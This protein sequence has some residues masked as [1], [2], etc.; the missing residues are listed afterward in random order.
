M[1]N[2]VINVRKE[3]GMTSFGVVSRMRRI[4][5]QKKIGHT[6]TLDPDAEGVLP[7]C[8]GKATRLVET[9][10]RGTKS[11]RAVLLLGMTTDT[12]DA[13]GT[14]LSTSDPAISEEALR[15]LILS[16]QGK[17]QQL[18]PMYSALKVDG[19]KLVDLA[20]RGIEVERKTREV[21][22]SEM[23]VHSVC[24]PRAEFSVTCTHGAYIRTLCHDIGQ[25]AGCP[26]HMRF[27]L[28]EQTGAFT[29]DTAVTVE[30]LKGGAA[31]SSLLPLDTPLSHLPRFDVP[32]CLQKLCL[33]GVRLRPDEWPGNAGAGEC[34]RLYLDGR[35]IGIS[36]ADESGML[37]PKAVLR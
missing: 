14:V 6:G 11:Y 5:D 36:Q 17:Q 9:L 22:F 25:A 21:E 28:R 19:K 34:V 26:A 23:E 20:R 15:A 7:V 18:P 1:I 32:P 10:S 8:L 27:L 29:L 35:L 31:E 4:F 2:G 37:I 16:F 12:Q 33:N 30:E 3:K 13:G 24:L